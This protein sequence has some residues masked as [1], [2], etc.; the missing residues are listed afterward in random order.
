VL[1]ITL[2][3]WAVLVLVLGAPAF[4]GALADR[5]GDTDDALRL[6][7]VRDL[8]AGRAGWYDQHFARLQPPFGMDLH[9][10][11]LVD[12]GIVGVELFFRLFLAPAQAEYAARVAWPLL[13]LGPALA[14]A[15]SIARSLRGE[16][17][18]FACAA[19]LGVTQLVFWQWSPGRIDHHDLQ[20]T[21]AL[22][23]LAGAVSGSRRGAWL[24][25]VVTACG[26]AVGIEG[27]MFLGLI[28]ASFAL[29]FAVDPAAH[30]RAARAYALALLGGLTALYLLEVPPAWWAVSHCDALG[31]NLLAGAMTACLGLLGMTQFAGGAD[32]RVRFAGLA[33]TGALAAAVYLGLEPACIRGPFA[34]ADPGIG[35]IWLSKVAEMQPLAHHV[36]NL[37][38]DAICSLE[39]LVL[40]AA[41]WL[42]LG[43]RQRSH[44]WL[45]VGAC[46]VVA[47]LADAK[48]VRLI[49]YSNLF[50]APL[51]AA[52][53]ADL[54][55]RFQRGRLAWAVGLA[56]V[57]SPTWPA[58][59]ISSL[60]RSNGDKPAAAGSCTAPSAY[61]RLAELPAGVVLGEID[62]G[63]YI[64]ASTRQAVLAAPYHRAGWGILAADAALAAT[65]G[66]DEAAVRRLHVDYVVE[67]RSNAWYP[68]RREIGPLSLQVRL[69]RGLAPVWLEA[70]SSPRDALQVY[71]VR[72]ARGA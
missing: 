53:V 31:A 12:G 40:G 67:C 50:A 70:V 22:C 20:I 29:R 71:R 1:W 34:L 2:A 62:L 25:G 33:G 9:W 15:V 7:L 32:V 64:L 11:R 4:A 60:A 59:Q 63:P 57:L 21:A 17:A 26:L 42:W 6:A 24:A 45:I 8:I 36:R 65:P 23:A 41:A 16:A 49:G 27:L 52:A 72:P 13:W 66:R 56:V 55:G 43:R 54:A 37:A 3:V 68:R 14:A 35:P 58:A 69:D 19:L 30:G 46:L 48:A 38:A 61:A 18:A 39:L 47:A 44:A 10:S 51:V 5:L 28:G